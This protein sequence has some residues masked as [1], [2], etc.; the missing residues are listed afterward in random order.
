V[1]D[2][3]IDALTTGN[4]KSCGCLSREKASER[5]GIDE[6]GNVYGKSTVIKRDTS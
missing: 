1:V 4:K 3:P 5:F 2:V 6:T